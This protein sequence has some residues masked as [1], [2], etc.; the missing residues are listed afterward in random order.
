MSWDH[1]TFGWESYEAVTNALTAMG[2]S[3]EETLQD[4]SR[5]RGHD[6]SAEPQRLRV[7]TFT[8]PNGKVMVAEEYLAVDDGDCDGQSRVDVSVYE[9][10]NRPQ[11][12][13]KVYDGGH[14][15]YSDALR[16]GQSYPLPFLYCLN[17]GIVQPLPDPDDELDEDDFCCEN[18]DQGL[19]PCERTVS[20]VSAP[21]EFPRWE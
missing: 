5:S 6:R 13:T 19:D 2:L 17:D 3:F 8:G 10:G 11:L 1:G 20:L 21:D 9:Q 7:A 15:Q 4:M 12:F 16:D 18:C 14:E